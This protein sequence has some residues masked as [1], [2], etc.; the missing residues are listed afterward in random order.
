M[1]EGKKVTGEKI[2]GKREEN[3]EGKDQGSERDRKW[4]GWVGG[5]RKESDEDERKN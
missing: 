3:K 5:R 2:G 4:E 1:R